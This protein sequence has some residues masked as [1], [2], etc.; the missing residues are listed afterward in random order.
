MRI[1]SLVLLIPALLF[2]ASLLAA[3]PEVQLQIKDRGFVPA[4]LEVP[5]NTKIKLVIHNADKIPAEFESYDLS[6]EV[7][8]PGGGEVTVYVGPLDKGEY[9]FFN[10]FH[11]SSTGVLTAR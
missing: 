5:A 9:K 1:R 8:V 4:Q 10:D 3:T 7:V 6:R 2:S 11:L